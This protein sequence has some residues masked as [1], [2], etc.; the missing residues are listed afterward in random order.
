MPFFLLVLPSVM[1]IVP[2]RKADCKEL[3][4]ILV[5]KDRGRKARQSPAQA[6]SDRL[7]T[8][9]TLAPISLNVVTIA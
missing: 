2:K 3:T 8:N 5:V 7:A 1:G 9:R 4:T 6:P